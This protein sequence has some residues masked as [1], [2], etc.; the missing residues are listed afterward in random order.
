MSTWWVHLYDEF[1]PEKVNDINNVVGIIIT[2]NEWDFMF[3][4]YL[5]FTFIKFTS[6]FF[7]NFIP[8]NQIFEI[9]QNQCLHFLK[10]NAI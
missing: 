5:Y 3:L 9:K 7:Q 2:A 6:I 1:L 10:K 4:I 8:L